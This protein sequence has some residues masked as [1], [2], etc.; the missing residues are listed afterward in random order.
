MYDFK[1]R[2]DAIV[3]ELLSEFGLGVRNHLLDENAR[4][5]II[6]A[7]VRHGK[8]ERYRKVSNMDGYTFRKK[9][10]RMQFM[11]MSV[12][13]RLRRRISQRRGKIKRRRKLSVTKLHM[14][15]A[16]RKRN[17]LGVV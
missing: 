16:L 8:V 3:D 6:K 10:G 11:K 4:W 2:L 17:S 9:N 15:R 5:R 14:Q 1:A 7:R 13:E 12:S